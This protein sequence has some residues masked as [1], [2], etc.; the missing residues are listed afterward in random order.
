M[1]TVL[2]M[3]KGAGSGGCLRHLEITDV[4][5]KVADFVGAFLP[6]VAGQTE[7]G[8]AATSSSSGR[9]EDEGTWKGKGKEK[10][11]EKEDGERRGL[12]SLSV[13]LREWDNEIL[14]A[15]TQH[16]EEL[17]KVKIRYE[18][19]FPSEVRFLSPPFF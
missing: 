1:G 12:W 13:V 18:D 14:F 7:G 3:L 4:D 8:Y 10:E 15:V 19:G 17:R 9:N 6:A 11:K 2:A 16:F 5:K